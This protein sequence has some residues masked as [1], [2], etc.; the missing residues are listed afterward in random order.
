MEKRNVGYV[1]SVLRFHLHP[2]KE[3]DALRCT[4]LLFVSFHQRYCVICTPVFV[5]DWFFEAVFVCKQDK[6]RLSLRLRLQNYSM[7]IFEIYEKVKFGVDLVN[8]W[9]IK[10]SFF[11]FF[12]PDTQTHILWATS[13]PSVIHNVSDLNLQHGQKV[14]NQ[15]W[16]RLVL[17]VSI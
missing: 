6:L 2:W 17:S 3:A 14:V 8:N 15:P 16:W 12:Y 1:D 10:I 9:Q 11:F 4:A 5:F 7:W 13:V